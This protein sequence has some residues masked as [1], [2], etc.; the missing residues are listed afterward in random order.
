MFAEKELALENSPSQHNETAT[1]RDGTRKVAWQW[2]ALALIGAL[3]AFLNFYQLDRVGYA[4][5]YYAAAVRSMMQNWHAF[6]FNSFDS[7][8]FVTIDKPP[9]GFWFQVLSAK[10]FGYSAV[11]LLLPEAL[12][13]VLSVLV[14]YFLVRRWFGAPAGLLAALVLAVTPVAVVDNRNNIID[15]MLT[16]FLLLGAWALMHAVETGRLRWLLLSAAIVGLGFNI[17]MLEAYLVVPALALTYL[18]AG[19]RA[20][21]RASSIW[22]PPVWCCLSSRCP[23]YWR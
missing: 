18:L 17:K 8:G 3:S 13:G 23:G 10:L 2:P 11:S 22:L 1:T 5:T 15:S 9:L 6:F 4:N 21:G 14:L 12:A 7:G 20:G 19:R 16:L